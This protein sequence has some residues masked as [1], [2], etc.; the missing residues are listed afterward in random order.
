[1]IV[2]A[3]VAAEERVVIV[4]FSAN[5]PSQM[6]KSLDRYRTQRNQRIFKIG[7]PNSPRIKVSCRQWQSM[8]TQ[9]TI[10]TLLKV[11]R[12]QTTYHLNNYNIICEMWR[13]CTNMYG[14]LVNC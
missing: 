5:M 12:R 10:C 14:S 11:Q 4:V 9:I 13:T 3:Y 7:A 1:M 6:H 2:W 8:Y